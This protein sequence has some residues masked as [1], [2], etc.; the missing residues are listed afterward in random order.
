MSTFPIKPFLESMES[1]DIALSLVLSKYITLVPRA[2]YFIVQNLVAII[3]ALHLVS[4]FVKS[5]IDFYAFFKLY[6]FSTAS[7]F[8]IVTRIISKLDFKEQQ[9]CV[10]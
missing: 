1:N 10:N 8:H 2:W 3:L 9:V 6:I 7:S 4:H 5:K